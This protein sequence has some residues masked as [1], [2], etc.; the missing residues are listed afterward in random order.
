MS[1]WLRIVYFVRATHSFTWFWGGNFRKYFSKVSEIFFQEPFG[2]FSVP[3]VINGL[4]SCL[5]EVIAIESIKK[6]VSHDTLTI[7]CNSAV[8]ETEAI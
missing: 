4:F 1:V 5:I 3:H 6:R 7:G 8:S 2:I